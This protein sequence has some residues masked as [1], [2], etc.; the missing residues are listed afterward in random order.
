MNTASAH[1]QVQHT[2]RPSWAYQSLVRPG[3]HQRNGRCL[4]PR[5]VTV[6]AEKNGLE[7]LLQ[8]FEGF[9]KEE[10]VSFRWD[11]ANLRWAK[12]KTKMADDASM[13]ITP[14]IGEPYLVSLGIRDRLQF[15]PAASRYSLSILVI[16]VWPAVHNYLQRKKLKTISPEEVSS[17]G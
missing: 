7:R 13:M 11:P 17:L 6:Q 12:S 4:T 10:E 5:T 2:H 14:L 9:S 8:P 15:L 3:K 1:A 16:Q